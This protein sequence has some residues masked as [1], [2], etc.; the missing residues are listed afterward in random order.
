MRCLW[1][2]CQ[3]H[4]VLRSMLKS[5]D[6]AAQPPFLCILIQITSKSGP[7]P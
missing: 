3:H 5:W 1:P 6:T 4:L 2:H 7:V